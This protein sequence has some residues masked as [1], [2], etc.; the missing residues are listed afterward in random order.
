MEKN[1]RRIQH[2]AVN[3][4]FFTNEELARYAALYGADE[5]PKTWVAEIIKRFIDLL[6][7]G[8]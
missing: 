1:M 5:I 3:P 7:A 6:D 2:E 4:V 8:K